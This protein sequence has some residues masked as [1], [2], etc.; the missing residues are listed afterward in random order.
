MVK[1]KTLLEKLA[2]LEH[3]QWS[4]WAMS[5]IDSEPSLSKERQERW[6]KFFV[7]YEELDEETKE[8]DREW[9]RRV[10]EI[11]NNA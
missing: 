5:L 4:T 8:F 10:L 11:I 6:A 7:P 9:A 3:V 2:A 1:D